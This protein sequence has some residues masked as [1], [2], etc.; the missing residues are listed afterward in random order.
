MAATVEPLIFGGYY[1]QEEWIKCLKVLDDNI[2]FAGVHDPVVGRIEAGF[3]NRSNL[4]M[5][6]NG[7]HLG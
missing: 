3:G 2:L 7:V 4:G 1:I 5:R 6:L